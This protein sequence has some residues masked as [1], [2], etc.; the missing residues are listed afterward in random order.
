[1]TTPDFPELLTRIDDRS[2]A[3]A[4]A[5]A[6]A[7]DDAPVPSCPD[8]TVRDLVGHLG[9]VQRFWAAI[10]AAG[11]ADAPP[12]GLQIPIPAGDLMEWYAESTERLRTA[13]EAAG[14][15]GRCW[16]WWRASPAPSS[17]GAVARHQVQEAA[18]HARDAQQAADRAEPL[19]ADIALDGVAEF[20]VVG[21]GSCGAW[22]D[23]P[24]RVAVHADEGGS[25][26]VDLTEA[27]AAVASGVT[28]PAPDA[29]L[30]GPACDL[31]L[32]LYG[33]RPLDAVGVAGDRA[34]VERLL[35]W[36]PFG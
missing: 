2:H 25:W 12:A 32:A 36:P 16:T 7:A 8:W 24:A 1:M 28:G 33:R 23:K 34:V 26:V 11:P 19:P 30:R 3:L 14:P 18:V 20:L 4:A 27:G 31:L 22:P 29:T 35:A 17:A 13:L 5:A 9:E 10:V 15:D 21:F 6:T